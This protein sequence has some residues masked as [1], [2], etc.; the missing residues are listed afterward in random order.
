MGKSRKK[1]IREV[2]WELFDNIYEECVL[3]IVKK[4]NAKNLAEVISRALVVY[5]WRNY[6]QDE[7]YIIGV[8]ENTCEVSNIKLAYSTESIKVIS[9]QKKEAGLHIV[10]LRFSPGMY[11]NL[12]MMKNRFAAPHIVDII[13]DALLTYEWFLEHERLGKKVGLIKEGQ[14]SIAVVIAYIGIEML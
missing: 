14:P 6:K 5:E 13:R 12:R 10:R 8:V 11:T 1:N 4:A 3:R 2:E 7:G 9:N